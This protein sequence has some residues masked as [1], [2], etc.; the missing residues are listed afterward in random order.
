MNCTYSLDAY[1]ERLRHDSRPLSRT[2]TAGDAAKPELAPHIV[3]L[4][5]HENLRGH[6]APLQSGC[7]VLADGLQDLTDDIAEYTKVV[8]LEVDES[9]SGDAVRF[10]SWLS[11]REDGNRHVRDSVPGCDRRAVEFLA[12]KRRVAHVR[13]Q[14]SLSMNEVLLP[15]LESNS[16][17]TV[18]LNPIH[19]W[20]RLET[21]PESSDGAAPPAV[22]V[23]PV[24]PDI[25]TVAIDPEAERLIR[26]LERH[27]IMRIKDLRKQFARGEQLALLVLLHELAEAGLIALG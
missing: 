23:Y 6:R 7:D 22:V 16:R 8:P 9:F 10:L 2:D 21:N 20:S 13:F 15:E 19:V 11:R 5:G 26:I 4:A 18:H 3:P 17:L 1:R 24:G 25:R 14:E 12:L 27:S